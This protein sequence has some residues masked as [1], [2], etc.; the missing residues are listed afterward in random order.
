MCDFLVN[1]DNI[2]AVVCTDFYEIVVSTRYVPIDLIDAKRG[3]F[4][5]T[6]KLPVLAQPARHL[7]NSFGFT[8]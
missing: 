1:L 7:G 2:F 6:V 8:L 4:L 3:V 5:W